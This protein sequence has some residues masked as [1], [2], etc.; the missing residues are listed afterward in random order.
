MKEVLQQILTELQTVKDSQVE[1]RKEQAEMREEIKFYYGSM[2][3]KLDETKSELR[4][5]IKQI[6]SVQKQHQEVLEIINNRQ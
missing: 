5:E 1:M 3:N 2:M 4:S 6:S